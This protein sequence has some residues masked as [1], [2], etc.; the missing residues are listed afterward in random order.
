MSTEAAAQTGLV[1]AEKMASLAVVDDFIETALQVAN[2][3]TGRVSKVVALANATRQVAAAV[4]ANWEAIAELQDSPLGFMTDEAT[5]K[6]GKYSETQLQTAVTHGIMLGGVPFNGEIT[7]IGGRAYLGKPHY[8]RIVGECDNIRDLSIEFGA[9]AF[10][11]ENRALVEAIVTWTSGDGKLERLEFNRSSTLDRRIPVRVNAGMGDD[12]IL[13]K[14]E[15]K[16]LKRVWERATGRVSQDGDE[17]N[18]VEGTAAPAA[19]PPAPPPPAY[20]AD[21][22]REKCDGFRGRLEKA[23]TEEEI[24]AVRRDFLGMAPEACWSDKTHAW[25]DRSCAAASERIKQNASRP[26]TEDV[27]DNLPATAYD[28]FLERLVKAQTVAEVGKAH[29]DFSAPRPSGCGRSSTAWTP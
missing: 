23:V 13:G 29:N 9:P 16:I 5:R 7:V 12:G 14:A 10:A 1:P 11:S 28:R 22:L 20:S 25:L 24:A 3:A 4:K 19:A 27:N 17:D 26:P 18:V 15:K 2:A 6:N 21:E 8:K